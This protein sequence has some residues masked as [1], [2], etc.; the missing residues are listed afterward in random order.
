MRISAALAGVTGTW[1]G[2]NL[3]RLMPTDQYAESAATATVRAVAGDNFVSLAYTWS[4][5]DDPQDGLLLI[6]DGPAPGQAVATWVDSWL[7]CPEW[8]VLR[9]AVDDAGAVHLQG[10]PRRMRSGAFTCGR[11]TRAGGCRWTTSCRPPTSRRWRRRSRRPGRACQ[12]V[13]ANDFL[14]R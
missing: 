6:G 7:Q 13:F 8:M 5:G 1:T 2:T 10:A 4:H 3:Q 12:E 11:A 14:Q 9:G